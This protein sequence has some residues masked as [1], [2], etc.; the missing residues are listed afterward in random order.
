L[1]P[2]PTCALSSDP[3]DRA[4][5]I[6]DK[7][8][9][10]LVQATRVPGVAFVL[11]HPA[12]ARRIVRYVGWANPATRE[13]IGPHSRFRIGSISKSFLTALAL[14]LVTKGVL[15]LD[16]PVL[17]RL[18][19][20]H[21]PAERCGGFD[22]N[23]VTLRRLLSH[24][25]GLNVH[26]FPD[27]HP[28]VP[29]R[30]PAELLD[31]AD[32]LE[33]CLAR[34]TS[35]PGT[36]VE[37]SGA[38]MTIVQV[39]IEDTLGVPYI[40]ALREHL[41]TPLRITATSADPDDVQGM[42]LCQGHSG[43]VSFQADVPPPDNP[44]TPH[45]LNPIHA[46]AA[47]GLFSTPNDVATVCSLPLDACYGPAGRGVIRADLARAMVQNQCHGAAGETW[48]LGLLL[49]SNER[50][51]VSYRHGGQ[52]QSWFAH[53]EGHIAPGIVWVAMAN[54][55]Y[56]GAC[57]INPIVASLRAEMESLTNVQ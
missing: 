24:S 44:L 34:L 50:G 13:P 12:T 9:P 19:S 51:I 40:V 42:S 39:L 10:Q 29:M 33:H 22:A 48:G 4:L 38:G 30:T 25:A 26:S 21:L 36:R 56:L 6:I 5:S 53:I 7:Q 46:T 15:D 3:F 32:N 54:A 27:V 31:G 41:L 28:C 17:P 14:T 18:R 49:Y 37:Y 43:G 2:A 20:W 23:R 8:L 45:P 52:R 16:E 55:D 11:S 35:E 57:A 1:N 47:S